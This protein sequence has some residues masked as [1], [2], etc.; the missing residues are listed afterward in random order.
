MKITKAIQSNAYHEA[1]HAVAAHKLGVRVQSLSIVT[2]DDSGGRMNFAPYFSGINLEYDSLPRTQ[3]RAEN[4]A[5]VCL[6]GPEAQKRFNPHGLRHY[7]AEDDYRQAV[8]ILHYLSSGPEEVSAY[9]ELIRIRAYAMINNSTV[10]PVICSVAERLID[11]HE[12]SGKQVR[13]TIAESTQKMLRARLDKAVI[14]GI[15]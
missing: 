2:N 11:E 14:K 8:D 13:E 6:A 10:W 7:H 1:G 5:L 15:N 3:R 9:F 4:Y 12:L